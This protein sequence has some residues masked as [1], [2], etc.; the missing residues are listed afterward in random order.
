MLDP[1][2]CLLFAL[3]RNAMYAACQLLRAQPGDEVLTPAFD[4]DGALQPFR[5]L[6]LRLRFYRSDP[7]TLAA[8]VDD[9]RQRLT[10]RTRLIHVINHFGF[11]QRWD[12]LLA[13]R[14][15]TGIP[16][17][18][19]N[20]YTLL[21]QFDHRPAGTF[22]DVAIFS[23]R[24]TLGLMDGGIL[25]LNRS[26]L[27]W[28]SPLGRPPWVGRPEL[29]QA[30]KLLARRLGYGLL[31]ATFRHSIR[32]AGSVRPPPPLYEDPTRHTPSWP[33]R[34]AIG[35]EFSCD[36]LRPMSHLARRQLAAFSGR[37]F[38]EVARHTRRHYARLVSRVRQLP[39]VRVLWPVLPDGIVPF[40]VCLLI[41]VGRDACLE[42]LSGRFGVMAWPTLPGEVLEQLEAFPE[43]ET[44]GRHWLQINLPADRARMEGFERE[45]DALVCELA[46]LIDRSAQAAETWTGDPCSVA[47]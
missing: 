34:D 2:R 13:L 45:L 22:G 20:A 40:S 37:D 4:C 9:L 6:G 24:K 41:D 39:G 21:S 16:I 18:E 32:H 12:D 31:P 26:D 27:R 30:V 42:A 46:S 23:L 44:L 33:A 19:D 10:T 43:V 17:L 28:D 7:E 11:P 25:R 36:P 8:N 3:G 15:A 35:P 29:P 5:V 1:D 38:A 47:A 14:H